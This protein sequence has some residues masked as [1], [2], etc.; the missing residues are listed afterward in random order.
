MIGKIAARRDICVIHLIY[1]TKMD[2][3]LPL[4]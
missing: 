3:V 4:S 1:K 2:I